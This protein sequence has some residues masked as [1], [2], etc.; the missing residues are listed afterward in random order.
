M[1]VSI[2][3]SPFLVGKR[4]TL[5]IILT[6]QPEATSHSSVVLLL[7]YTF[8][9]LKCPMICSKTTRRRNIPLGNPRIYIVCPQGQSQT[10][11]T[12][13]GSLSALEQAMQDLDPVETQEW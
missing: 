7:V 8:E 4:P 6:T 3:L 1:A 10:Q 11:A 9:R 13:S 5:T 12:D 2:K